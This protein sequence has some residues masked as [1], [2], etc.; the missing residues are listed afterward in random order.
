MVSLEP[1]RVARE[2]AESPR[3]A[4]PRPSL[5]EAQRLREQGYRHVPLHVR[6]SADDLTPVGVFRRLVRQGPGFLLESVEAGGNGV[7][8]YSFIGDR[9]LAILSS[10]GRRVLLRQ[11]SGLQRGEPAAGDRT[12]AERGSTGEEGDVLEA[13]K[14]VVQEFRTAPAEGLPRF[15][16]GAVGYVGYD[17]VHTLEPVPFG[18]PDPLDLPTSFWLVPERL[19]VLDHVTSTATVIVLAPTDPEGYG[20]AAKLLEKTLSDLRRHPAERSGKP[21]LAGEVTSSFTEEGFCQ[22]VARA[23]EHIA[24]GDIFQVVLSQ[25]LTTPF[26]GEALELYRALREENPSPYLFLL[27]CGDFQVVGSS[28][29]LLVRLEDGVAETRP[30]AGTRPRGR[31]SAEDQ[32]LE[33]E[34]RADAK[35]CAEHVMLVDLGRNDLGRVCRPGTVQVPELMA[36]ERFSRVMHLVSRVTGELA[37]GED[38]F[39]LLRAVFPAGTLTGAPKVRAMQIIAELEPFQRGLYG[40]AVGYFGFHGSLDAC[41]AIRTAVLRHGQACVQ[42]GAGIVAD[43]EPGREYAESLHKAA[44]VLAAIRKA[45]EGSA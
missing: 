42:A 3:R 30:L 29:E 9:P 25:R 32:A 38:A 24:A 31:D 35:E 5:A 26:A 37:P 17:Y 1:Y 45:Q 11:A 7:G 28:P 13:L 19:V 39:S 27:D 21:G 15:Y 6:F 18:A 14:R 2:P 41:I 16:G 22:A 36:V 10:R 34:L 40:G 12:A 4:Q 23:K 20:R 8:R 43:S 44:A 33:A